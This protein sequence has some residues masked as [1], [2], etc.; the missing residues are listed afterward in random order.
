MHTLLINNKRRH[1]S[2]GET[3]MSG[4]YFDYKQLHIGQIADAI[5]EIVTG[6]T[7][8][9]IRWET[10][11]EAPL[12]DSL[13]EATI[14]EFKKAVEVLRMAATYAHRIDW[15]LSSDDNEDSFRKRLAKDL[16]EEQK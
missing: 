11:E 6:E 5:E 10:M 2:K 13:G 15:L 16:S 8:E 1:T 7:T 4:G 14:A 12:R 9:V 3:K